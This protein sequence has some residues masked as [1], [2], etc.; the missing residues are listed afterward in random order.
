MAKS[1]M[2]DLRECDRLKGVSNF[3]PWK[4]R[5]QMLMEAIYLCAGKLENQG[6]CR[7]EEL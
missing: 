4:F 7:S 3:I 6:I 1:S 5:L 2:T